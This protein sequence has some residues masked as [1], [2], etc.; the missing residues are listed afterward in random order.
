MRL[1]PLLTALAC[2]IASNAHGFCGFYVARGDARL[3]NEASQVVMVR[4]ENRTVITMVN[5]FEGDVSD[6]AMVIPTPSVLSER[7]IHVTE[8]AIV[9]HLDAYTAPRLVEY[10]DED[11]CRPQLFERSIA[12]SLA[13]PGPGGTPP[14]GDQA[15]GVTVEAEYLVGAY[16][17]K[18]LSAEQSEGLALW[19]E[20]N[21]YRTPEGAAPVLARYLEAGMKF[22]VA[23]IDLEAHAAQGGGVLRPLQI[24]F[25]SEAF[26]LPIRLGMLNAKGSQDLILFTLTRKGRVET[27]NYRTVR[28]PTGQE[29][30]LFT[31]DRFGEAYKA[32]FGQAVAREGGGAVMLEYA[33]DMAWCDPCAADP[34]SAAELRE[35]GAYWVPPARAGGGIQPGRIAAPQD[36][37]VTRLHARYDAETFPEDLR[38]EVTEDRENFQGRYILRHPYRGPAVCEAAESYFAGLPKRF[39][40]E[41][42]TLAN[43]TGWDIATIR[44]EMAAAGQDPS[45]AAEP[46]AW[47]ETIWPDRTE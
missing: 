32:I 15:L 44:A 20:Q 18:I 3:F 1:L 24:A 39:E 45:R 47:W 46:P 11:P 12:L 19:L 23:K 43:L 13:S 33:W 9:S 8:N 4:D 42:Q 40:S 36:V 38:L 37:F 16:D 14:S 28:I 27:T 31:R 21:G 6:F 29:L 34:L 17:I 7:Q 30:P 22:F 10:Y 26:M 2:A 35:L 5:D 41:A 25:E